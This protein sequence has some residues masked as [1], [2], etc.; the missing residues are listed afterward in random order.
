VFLTKKLGIRENLNSVTHYVPGSGVVIMVMESEKPDRVV[1]GFIG[2]SRAVRV[3]NS[4]ANDQ[5]SCA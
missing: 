4:R 3:A 5:P 2:N 1:M